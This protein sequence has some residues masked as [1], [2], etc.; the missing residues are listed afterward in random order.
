MGRSAGKPAP[1]PSSCTL[2]NK[3]LSMTNQSFQS[4]YEVPLPPND[5]FEAIYVLMEPKSEVVRYVGK[6]NYPP[7]RLSDHVSVAKKL[8]K[9]GRKVMTGEFS[10]SVTDW[11]AELLEQN[12]HPRMFVIEVVSA[13]MAEEVERRW[14]EKLS[15]VSP[16]L[17]NDG[18]SWR[19]T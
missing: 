5:G 8:K 9:R 3:Q 13:N 6:S 19:T 7:R 11:I 16:S 10:Y 14:I 12:L 17:L 15:Q 1:R 4:L 2:G 18:P